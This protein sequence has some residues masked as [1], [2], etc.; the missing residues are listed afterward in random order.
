MICET[1]TY[2]NLAYYLAYLLYVLKHKPQVWRFLNGKFGKTNGE[3]MHFQLDV[4]RRQSLHG[5]KQKLNTSKGS[6]E[7]A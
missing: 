1:L 6:V 5:I 3:K 2:L 7:P 4:F